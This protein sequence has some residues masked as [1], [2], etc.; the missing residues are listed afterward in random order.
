MLY[1]ETPIGV[2]FSYADDSASHMTMDDG[3]TGILA[4]H[5]FKGRV[6][7]SFSFRR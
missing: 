2:G 5:L 4:S 6:I 1:L 3:A 7:P